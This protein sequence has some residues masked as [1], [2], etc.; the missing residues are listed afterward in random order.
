MKK[1][2]IG[3]IGTGG[4]VDW[5]HMPAF[6]KNE[7]FKVVSFSSANRGEMEALAKRTGIKQK[8]TARWIYNPN[9]PRLLPLKKA[10][11]VLRLTVWALR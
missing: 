7:N 1:I 11:E 9:G 3:F 8:N 2:K 5:G 10:A 6:T 4:I